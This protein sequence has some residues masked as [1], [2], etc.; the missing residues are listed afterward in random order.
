MGYHKAVVVD[1]PNHYL[2]KDQVLKVI[3]PKARIMQCGFTGPKRWY[4]Q[5][6]KT[7]FQEHKFY[8]KARRI[9]T[10]KRYPPPIG[11]TGK[12]Q[13]LDNDTE[14]YTKNAENKCSKRRMGGVN[15]SPEVIVW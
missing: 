3:R 6:C 11:F 9:Y 4:I 8:S 13:K 14:Q 5:K 1:I 2:L 10:S 12:L 15:F 7:L